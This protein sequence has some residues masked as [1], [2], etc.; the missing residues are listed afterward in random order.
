VRRNFP[1]SKPPICCAACEADVGKD[2]SRNIGVYV[3]KDGAMYLHLLCNGCMACAL[4][5]SE[6][7]AEIASL[8]E[9]YFAPSGGTA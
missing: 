4:S 1:S 3:A 7:R 5:S 2:D 9:L 6:G 8:V